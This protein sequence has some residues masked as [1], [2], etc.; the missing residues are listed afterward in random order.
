[1]NAMTHRATSLCIARS[2]AIGSLPGGA[3]RLPL[4]LRGS[5]CSDQPTRGQWE[6]QKGRPSRSYCGCVGVDISRAWCVGAIH[7]LPRC[8]GV[9]YS[10]PRC[11][12]VVHETPTLPF[13]IAS[14]RVAGPHAAT[15][16]VP[17]SRLRLCLRPRIAT[18]GCTPHWPLRNL[19]TAAYS[20]HPLHP[21]TPLSYLACASAHGAPPH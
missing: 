18:G 5:K 19:T 12:G 14:R 7:P 6:T 15:L 10:L 20:A 13:L 16:G 2:L 4:S 21:H 9:T 8:L 1:M 11:M 3:T 17:A